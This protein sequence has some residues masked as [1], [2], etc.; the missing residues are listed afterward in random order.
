MAS[1]IEVI[2]KVFLLTLFR[3]NLSYS[4]NSDLYTKDDIIVYFVEV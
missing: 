3:K 4:Q 1:T 2:F